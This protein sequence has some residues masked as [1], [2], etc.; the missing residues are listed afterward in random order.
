MADYTVKFNK[1]E[2]AYSNEA[3]AQRKL[4][5]LA[6]QLEAVSTILSQRSTTAK[7]CESVRKAAKEVTAHGNYVKK[8]LDVLQEASAVYENTDRQVRQHISQVV[9]AEAG[10]FGKTVKAAEQGLMNKEE[11]LDELGL[12]FNTL[13]E[14]R[15]EAARLLNEWKAAYGKLSKEEQEAIEKAAKKILGEDFFDSLVLTDMIVTGESFEKIVKK[16]GDTIIQ[17]DW[18]KAVFDETVDY[19]YD[20]ETL[21]QVEMMEEKA[22]QQILDGDYVGALGTIS[23]G[24]VDI[25]GVG[26]VEVMTNTLIS[27]GEKIGDFIYDTVRF[28][29]KLGDYIYDSTHGVYGENSESVESLVEGFSDLFREA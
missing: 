18:Y 10:F 23:I 2:N 1:W 7:Y 22:K 12:I 24:F 14:N 20:K 6:D 3:A 13:G 16:A 17:D 29:E 25:V 27:A 8:L 15:D 11:A 5:D 4:E 9:T 28:G 26:S 21:A 19:T